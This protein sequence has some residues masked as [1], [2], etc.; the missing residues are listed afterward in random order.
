MTL[1]TLIPCKTQSLRSMRVL[2]L[3]H[4][5]TVLLHSGM[6]AYIIIV[7]GNIFFGVENFFSQGEVCVFKDAVGLQLC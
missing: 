1:I 5:Q 2:L 4:A 7:I 6:D 3:T